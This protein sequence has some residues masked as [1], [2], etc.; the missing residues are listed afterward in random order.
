MP[1]PPSAFHLL[2][3]T[4]V[5]AQR[6][7]AQGG[8]ASSDLEARDFRR[9]SAATGPQLAWAVSFTHGDGRGQDVAKVS[10]RVAA[11]LATV[12]SAAVMSSPARAGDDTAEVQLL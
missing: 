4:L 10:R 1:S 7:C 12:V 5:L 9:V 2:Q 6:Q 3:T 8:L 11:L